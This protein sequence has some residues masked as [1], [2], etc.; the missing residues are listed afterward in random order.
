MKIAILG[1]GVV[2]ETLGS[3]LVSLGHEVRMGSRTANHEKAVAWTRKAGPLASQG[4]F[5]DAAAFAEL[6]FN[7]TLGTASVDAV[8]SAG[9][10]NLRGKVLVDVSNPLDFSKGFPPTLSVTNTDSLGEQLQRAVPELKVVKALNTMTAS[11]MVSPSSLP[12]PHDVFVCG[13]DAGAKKLVTSL[14]TEGFGWKRVLDVGDITASRGL[15]G[16]LPLVL[17]LYQSFGDFDFNLHVV[18]K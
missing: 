5:A 2:G 1:T 6:L 7:C 15:E 8:K 13:D 3:K 17:R 18:R 16:L 14:L 12:A 9:V 11:I 10:E 4:T